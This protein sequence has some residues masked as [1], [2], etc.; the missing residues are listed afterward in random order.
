V[1]TDRLRAPNAP[2]RAGTFHG[3]RSAR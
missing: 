2:Q 1:H 3:D